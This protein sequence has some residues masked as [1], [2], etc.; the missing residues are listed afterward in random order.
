MSFHVFRSTRKQLGFTLT[1]IMI[2]VAIVSILAAIGLPAYTD[3]IIRSRLTEVFSTLATQQTNAEQ[4]WSDR[5]TYVG[6]PSSTIASSNFTYAVT[7]QTATSY[8]I[9]ATGTGSMTGFKFTIDQANTRAT[10][11]VPTGWTAPSTN[12]WTNSKGGTCIK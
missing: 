8:L 10:T 7:G 6:F 5:R 1:E 11:G 3:Y 4:Y 2:T 12:C 9:T